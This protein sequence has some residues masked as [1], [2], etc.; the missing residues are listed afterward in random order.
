[1]THGPDD[2]GSK[3]SERSVY[4]LVYTTLSSFWFAFKQCLCSVESNTSVFTAYD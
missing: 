1:M 2:L 4:L 3:Q